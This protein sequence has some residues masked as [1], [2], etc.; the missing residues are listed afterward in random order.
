MKTRIRHPQAKIDRP[1]Q[2]SAGVP[3][4]PFLQNTRIMLTKGRIKQAMS[5]R[6]IGAFCQSSPATSSGLNTSS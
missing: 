2:Q 4:V 6:M 3:R 1:R 5:A